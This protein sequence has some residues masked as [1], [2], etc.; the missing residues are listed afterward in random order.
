[1]NLS[2]RFRTIDVAGSR[3]DA[4]RTTGGVIEIRGGDQHSLQR[5][6]GFFHAHDR[7]V[8]MLLVR[9]IGQG[10]LCECLKDD[11]E[12]LAIDI[13]MRQ[14]AFA[15]AAH[16]ESGRLSPAARDFAR[17]YADGVNEYLERHSRP[18]EFRLVGYRPDPWEPADTL[19]TIGLMSY[20]GLAQTQQD[21]EK[22]LI[23]MIQQGTDV[24]RLKQLFA[25]HLEGLSDEIVELIR[26]VRLVAPLL[27]PLPALL[28][29]ITASNN[30]AVAPARSAT[31]NPL[32][33]HDPHLEC[34]RLP[35]V[36]YEAVLHTPD[37]YQAGITMPGVPGIIMGRTRRLSAGFTYGFMD[38]VDYFIEECRGGSFRRDDGWQPF[39][40]R[41]E[42]IWRKREKAVE[43]EV[44]ENEH[45]TL[46]CAPQAALP[47]GFYLCRAYSGRHC[48]AARSL[49]ALLA[50]TS[51]ETVH[52][53]R[54]ALRQVSISCNWVVA[55]RDGNIACQ[56]SGL[57]PRRK[58]SGLYPVPGW[59]R[60]HAWQGLV[61]AE[62]LAGFENPPEGFLVTANDDR[63]LPGRPQAMNL[64]QGSYRAERIAE[65]L[66]EKPKLSIA[67]MQRMQSDL[68]SPQARRFM[69][70]LRKLLPETGAAR[71]LADWDL[72]YDPASRGATLFEAFYRALLREVF[73][74]GLFGDAAWQAFIST[75]NLLGVYF[76][77]FDEALLG[78]DESWFSGRRR[79]EVFR[80]I[81]HDVL[82]VPA[83]HVRPWGDER[84]M[85]MIN[86]FFGGRLPGILNRLVKVD[87]GPFALP[88][89]RATIAQGQIFR[90][91]GRLTT[92]APSYRSV[93]D[94][95][96]DEL[97][98]VLAGGPSGRILSPL[99]ASDLGRWLGFGYKT[100]K[101]GGDT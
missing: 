101:C 5:G 14:M 23:Q 61:P 20:V 72:C 17:A 21:V 62:E 82:A 30:W 2:E 11:A 48:G 60:D 29:G 7:L 34:N 59:W 35:A 67:D 69:A 18:L 88:G 100:L 22:F 13:F 80:A 40:R 57:L 87:Y 15:Q 28:P 1:M 50:M 3:L 52:E 92:F 26:K 9:L 39:R 24:G 55:D 51:A 36:W 81:L 33:C 77:V 63:N 46:E 74:K 16:D 44:L 85:T 95:G 43:I 37:D 4:R 93:T 8:Q 91:H 49:E 27:P 83:E 86:L 56:Q 19:L 53:A 70:H 76:Q 78:N 96:T 84:Q 58:T 66:R 47:D 90:T 97:H 75:T 64:C 31:G 73:G 42:T 12:S 71:I 79:D 99:Y 6:L 68:L 38:M 32:E 45:G 41:R 94:L 65:L 54:A 10:R 98:T 25:P 89:G